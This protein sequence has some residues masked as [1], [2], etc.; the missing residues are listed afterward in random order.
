[1]FSCLQRILEAIFRALDLELTTLDLL[2]VFLELECKGDDDN[3]DDELRCDASP[4]AWAVVRGVLFTEDLDSSKQ[5]LSN[6]MKV[7]IRASRRCHQYHRSRRALLSRRRASSDRG[8]CSLDRSCMLG[9]LRLPKQIS[10]RDQTRM[11]ELTPAQTRKTPKYRT[12][13]LS[14]QPISGRPMMQ[15]TELTRM[16]GP[17]RCFLSPYQ[18]VKYTGIA[19]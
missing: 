15:M 13:T 18:P 5:R 1:M 17:R 2:V 7:H 9:Y 11:D 3:N 14:T 6:E 10:N 8:C 12:P 4:K 19:H 16:I